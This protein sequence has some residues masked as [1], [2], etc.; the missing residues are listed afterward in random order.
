[1]CGKPE[2]ERRMEG[3]L[4]V[5]DISDAN[6]HASIQQSQRQK[7]PGSLF[8]KGCSYSTQAKRGVHMVDDGVI[9][10][11]MEND[12]M[13]KKNLMERPSSSYGSAQ[14]IELRY[15]CITQSRAWNE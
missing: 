14:G 8:F 5:R 9:T 15:N 2:M 6:I 10:V 4:L 7:L 3:S 1:M 13:G 11:K 12:W